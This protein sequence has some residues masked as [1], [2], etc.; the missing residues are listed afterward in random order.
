MTA[1]SRKRE[2]MLVESRKHS[3][4]EKRRSLA[5]NNL[6]IFMENSKNIEEKR[7]F[8]YKKQEKLF[9]EISYDKKNKGI[10]SYNV[11]YN[12]FNL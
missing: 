11:L 1:E 8:E 7:E 10:N 3:F 2:S 5:T 6:L 9:H 12:Y 4:N